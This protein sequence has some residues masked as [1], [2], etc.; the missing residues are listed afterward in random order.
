MSNNDVASVHQ[1]RSAYEGEKAG[2]F[3]LNAMIATPLELHRCAVKPEWVDYN[4]HMSESCY[5]LVFGDNS[6]AFFRYFGIDD[7]YRLG[8]HSIY[9]VETHI[10]NLR[11]VALGEPVRLTL[12]LLDFDHKRLH[13]FHEMWH[14]ASNTLLATGEQLLMHVDMQAGRA[15][16]LPP[17]LQARLE[18]IRTVHAREPRPVDAGRAIAINHRRPT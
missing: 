14:A 13:I 6:D 1:L 8:G 9:T 4:Q 16:S 2:K 3:D 15:A 11:E 7:D 10:R 17:E 18:V 12:R 5:L